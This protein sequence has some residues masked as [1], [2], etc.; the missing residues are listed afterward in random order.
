MER[1]H[2]VYRSLSSRVESH[3]PKVIGLGGRDECGPYGG[4]L[5]W[6]PKDN[7]HPSIGISLDNTDEIEHTV[8]EMLFYY[9][10][11]EIGLLCISSSTCYGHCFGRDIIAP[12]WIKQRGSRFSLHDRRR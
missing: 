10:R 4:V 6:Q 1:F 7:A 2:H 12:A 3:P 8:I 9:T 5:S 11:A